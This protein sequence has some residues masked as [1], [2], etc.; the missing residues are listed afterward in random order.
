MN[1]SFTP[2]DGRRRSL[3]RMNGGKAW[4]FRMERNGKDLWRSTGTS[5]LPTARVRA[6]QKAD[7]I[8]GGKAMDTNASFEDLLKRFEASRGKRHANDPCFAKRLRTT[9]GKGPG[10]PSAGMQI[11]A[12]NVKPGDLQTWLTNQSELGTKGKPWRGRTINH[13]RLWLKQMFD[14]AVDDKL[15]TRD[16]HPFASKVIKR[17]R[18]DPVQR[19]IPTP[20]Q[21]AAIIA[22]I[23]ANHPVKD[24][25]KPHGP[26]LADFLEFLALA[27]VGQA[28]AQRLRKCDVLGNKMRF[29]RQKTGVPFE[30]PIYSWLAPLVER[31]LALTSKPT[32]PLL[33]NGEA[34]KALA[35]ACKRLGF[36][37]FTPRGLRAMLIRRL[38][39]SGVP[40]KRIALW[41]GHRDGGHLI[42]TTYTEVF[43]DLDKAAEQADLAKV[44]GA[45][46]IAP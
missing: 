46:S 31:R 18:L 28:E 27:G 19:N 8:L 38:Y 44:G 41:Q 42:Q 22:D 5:D 26:E 10:E 7:E 36:T 32:D 34:G 23:R 35:S 39:D 15:I 17:R 25:H 2:S 1:T 13:Y 43:S 12:R 6:I 20:E 3:F 21:L 4:Y 9:F 24:G 30:V 33:R 37:H 11:K 40:I 16:E 45:V 14:L 29:I